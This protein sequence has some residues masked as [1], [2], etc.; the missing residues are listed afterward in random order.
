MVGELLGKLHNNALRYACPFEDC[1][2]TF[3]RSEF[4]EHVACCPARILICG[5]VDVDGCG[6]NGCGENMTRG[7]RHSSYLKDQ[8]RKLVCQNIELEKKKQSKR[9]RRSVE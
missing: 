9:R 6:G 4:E 3:A 2:L 1:D 5:V 7:N 8:N